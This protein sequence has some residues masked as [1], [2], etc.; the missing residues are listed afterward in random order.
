MK[1]IRL[2]KNNIY[3]GVQYDEIIY[4]HGMCQLH[5]VSIFSTLTIWSEKDIT[6]KNI[7]YKLVSNNI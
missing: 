4:T 5:S 2:V 7:V 3:V 1:H 6:P